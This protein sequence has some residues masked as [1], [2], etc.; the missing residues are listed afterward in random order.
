MTR[1]AWGGMRSGRRASHH[2]SV[3]CIGSVGTN[4]DEPTHPAA[5]LATSP[6]VSRADV[7]RVRSAAGHFRGWEVVAGC[8]VMATVAW[9][10]CFYGTGFYLADLV[11]RRAL[12][13]SGVSAGLTVY[14]W[15]SAILIM[16]CG[17]LIDRMGPRISTTIGTLAM[18]LAVCV[19][20]RAHTLA[21]LYAALAAMAVSWTT[22]TSSAIN[23]ILAPW[24]MRKRGV[25]LSISLTG[26]SF[27]GIAVVP[28][29]SATT[30]AWGHATGLTVSAL[31]LG[32][33]TLITIWRCFV[34]NPS[35]VGQ[36]PDGDLRPMPL[37]AAAAIAA[38]SGETWP[39]RRV[40]SSPTFLS[41][42]VAFSIALTV[43]V[44]FLTHQIS[45]LQPLLGKQ[46]A[47]WAVGT[48]T[49]SSLLGRMLAGALM[50]R[51]ERR[52]LAALNFVAQAT[53][54]ALLAQASAAPQIYAA[55]VLAGLAVGNA[56][57]FVGL[58][59]QREF[60]DAQFNRVNR[61]AVGIG[62]I[63]Y[64]CGPLLFGFMRERSG[65][66]S[67]PLYASAVVAAIAAVLVWI[68]RP[69]SVEC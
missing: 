8:F 26:A 19:I 7:D 53:G 40:L 61:L 41:T 36:Y 25:A 55:C 28:L 11:G 18:V 64:A 51:V 3:V 42:C 45:V 2:A 32:A 10:L 50:D 65:S 68:G 1:D 14:F 15:S 12:P 46:G 48:T 38:E 17:R 44:G 67:L 27:G 62:Q 31:G 37:T 60:P 57:T 30:H 39:L 9:G 34:R 23:T 47:A 21:A 33:L 20:G 69:R 43:Q 13:I 66:Y 49:V 35:Q 59:V 4:H 52:A 58:L 16:S 56:I 5:T 54:M 63:C 24:F 22:M 29:L 6:R